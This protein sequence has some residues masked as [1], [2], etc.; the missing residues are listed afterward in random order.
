MKSGP[1]VCL[2]RNLLSG[3]PFNGALHTLTPVS[4]SQ[5]GDRPGAH[6]RGRQCNQE[7]A[8]IISRLLFLAESGRSVNTFGFRRMRANANL[9]PHTH[10][11]PITPRRNITTSLEAIQFLSR[12]PSIVV[13]S[14]LK[15][16]PYERY[17]TQLNS[18][19]LLSLPYRAL[20]CLDKM[21]HDTLAASP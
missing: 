21:T 19:N 15:R 16:S 13:L 8:P 5:L 17:N 18:S 6:R 12:Y 2:F 3:S 7:E 1:D 20:S 10:W 14:L 11:Q 4:G 9:C